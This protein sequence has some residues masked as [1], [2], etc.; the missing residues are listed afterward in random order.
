VRNVHRS[1]VAATSGPLR[2]TGARRI[3]LLI[4][5]EADAEQI[6]VHLDDGIDVPFHAPLGGRDRFLNVDDACDAHRHRL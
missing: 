3:R 2:G 5:C 6:W 1:Q 4:G